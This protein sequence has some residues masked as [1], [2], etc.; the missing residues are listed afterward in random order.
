MLSIGI[1]AS[2]RGSNLQAIL[3]ACQQQRIQ[4]EVSLVLS[5]N[6]GAHALE[7]AASMG[8]PTALLDH[9]EFATRDEFEQAAADCMKAKGVELVCLAGFMRLLSS[10]FLSAFP[11]RVLN[12]H[13]SLLP[14]FPG[15]HAQ[16]QALAAGVR[17]TGC[18]VHFVDEGMDTGPIL[19]QAVIP[20]LPGDNET[21]LSARILEQEHRLFPA[22]I[23][24]LAQRR[25]RIEG[26]QVHVEDVKG[27][28]LCLVNPC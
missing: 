13:P 25:V 6:P 16:A 9:R 11:G 12:I 4:A 27:P 18:T 7:R 8:V 19:M 22:A 26:R 24:L 28:S 14:S 3:D 15:L 23:D 1:L 21:T 20:V 10:T 5:N 2:G 17:F